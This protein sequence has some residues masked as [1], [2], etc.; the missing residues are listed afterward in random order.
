MHLLHFYSDT[1][2]SAT[3]KIILLGEFI[4]KIFTQPQQFSM[5]LILYWCHFKNFKENHDKHFINQQKRLQKYFLLTKTID[6]T[7]F[8]FFRSLWINANS[9]F[10]L[11]AIDV[12]RF[13]PPASGDTIMALRQSVIFSRIHFRTAGSAYKL[14]TG[15]SKKPF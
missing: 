4:I 5:T 1:S 12:T 11:S 3:F 9:T 13:A 14:S 10:N 15:M 2:D 7:S 6:A 8:A